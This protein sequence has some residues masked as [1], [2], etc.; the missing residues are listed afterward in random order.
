MDAVYILMVCMIFMIMK[1]DEERICYEI[2]T[3][4]EKYSMYLLSF[5]VIMNFDMTLCVYTTFIMQWLCN[6][7]RLP[8]W[9]QQ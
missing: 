5:W 3:Y 1:I 6:E 8:H 2:D 7:L 4:Y 9:L